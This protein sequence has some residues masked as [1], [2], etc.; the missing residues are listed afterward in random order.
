[1]CA[2]AAAVLVLLAVPGVAAANP[3]P[4]ALRAEG[5]SVTWPL[6]ADPVTLA[7]GH[8]L[9]VRVRSARRLVRVALLR[10]SASERP[11]HVVAERRLRRGTF[12]TRVPRAHGRHYLLALW[13]GAD[14]YSTRIHAVE[15]GMPP[16][17]ASAGL[18]AGF[19]RLDR[20]TARRDEVLSVEVVNTGQTCLH[21][22]WDFWYERLREDGSWERVE[23]QP[24]PTPA[25]AVGTPPGGST[26]H[27]AW[28][29][30]ELQPG[31]HRLVK[32]FSVP[33]GQITLSAEFDVVA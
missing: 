32:T 20:T 3:D 8:P 26:R 5:V 13:V 9:R 2:A 27:D 22:G 21:G 28:V 24:Y 17:C 11:M 33:E 16:P 19:L 12:R 10:V 18:T 4:D 30:P 7:P 23:T 14:R 25:I 29:F 15:P 1:M 6:R 31:R